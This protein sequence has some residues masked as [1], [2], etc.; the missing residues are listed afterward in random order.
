MRLL[1]AFCLGVSAVICAQQKSA[2]PPPEASQGRPSEFENQ[3]LAIQVLPGWTTATSADETSNLLKGK[4]LL[5]INPMFTHASGVIGGRFSEIV[6]G[7]ESI[8]A[9]M[10][11]VDQPAGGFE[12]SA[13]PPEEIVATEQIKLRN[14]Y[15]DSSK[16]GN[17]CIFPSSARPIWF[18]SYFSGQ[19]SESDYAITLTYYTDDVNALPSKDSPELALIFREVTQMLK[20][21]ELKPPIIISKVDPQSAPSG[22]TV[23]IY[24]RGFNLFNQG[25]EVR[26]S[27]FPNNPMPAPIV[28][29]DGK[30]LT[31][32]VPTSINTISC[33]PALSTLARSRLWPRFTLDH[34]P[35][36]GIASRRRPGSQPVSVKEASH[37]SALRSLASHRA[38]G[39]HRIRRQFHHAHGAALSQRRL[40]ENPRRGQSPP[41]PARRGPEARSLHL[42]VRRPQQL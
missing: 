24:G 16:A 4:Y 40:P 5:S 41:R 29:P 15:S 13:W 3:F 28:A 12:C 19:A 39:G 42:P 6:S 33:A 26:F 10:H 37:G 1:I 20:T 30:S 38:L 14:L 21:L 27:D 35:P 36:A 8:D 22:A 34:R 9:V 31:F 18:G 17:G 11:N 32:Q 7:K 2:P 25:S 23:T